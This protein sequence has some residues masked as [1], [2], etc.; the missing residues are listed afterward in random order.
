MS[1]IIIGKILRFNFKNNIF[2]YGS[3]KAKIDS[4]YR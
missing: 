2:L 3:N 1:I 4:S